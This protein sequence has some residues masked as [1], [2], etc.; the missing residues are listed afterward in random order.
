MLVDIA[1]ERAVLSGLFN[2]G[3]DFLLDVDYLDIDCFSNDIN[4]CLYKILVSILSEVEKADI[5]TV[6]SKGGALG[7]S[8]IVDKKVEYINNIKEYGVTYENAVNLA[9]RIAR[10]SIVRQAK[11][12]LGDILQELDKSTGDE[13]VGEI[14]SKIESP[15]VD[16]SLNVKQG[17]TAAPILLFD[18]SEQYIRH[19]ADN[20]VQK[21]GYSTGFKLMDEAIGG[22]FRPGSITMFSLRTGVGKSHLARIF[23]VHNAKLGVKTLIIDT[24]MSKEDIVH[25]S[26]ADFTDTTIRDIETGKF[27]Y[28]QNTKD[29]LI[30]TAKEVKNIPLYY[31]SVAGKSFD[32]ILSVCRRWLIREVG[33]DKNGN[34]NPSIIIYDY[35]KLMNMSGLKELSEHQLLG[36][37]IHQLHDLC[38]QYKTACVSFIQSNRDGISNES[39][40]S[41]SQSDR[42]AWISDVVVMISQKSDEELQEDGP[43]N[44]N[45]KLAVLKPRHGS[46]LLQTDRI[47]YQRE[48]QFSRFREIGLK[49]QMRTNE[50]F[51]DSKEDVKF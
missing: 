17:D 25:R 4:Q 32:E 7:L 13:P 8:Q 28:N 5:P 6:I 37:Y 3:K 51:E 42:L 44:G 16:F 18:D 20:P 31:K 30:Q 15:V 40:A 43:E 1:A 22:G 26:F 45:L 38:V 35:F 14:L 39:L 24:E 46:N 49:S 23:G 41:L 33:T 19:L 27:G 29:K 11:V 36:M 48:G 50:G 21:I 10:L 2:Y 34:W 9:K 47:F 12:K